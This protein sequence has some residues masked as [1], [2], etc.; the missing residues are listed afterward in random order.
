MYSNDGNSENLRSLEN[1]QELKKIRL[2]FIS[3]MISYPLW[4]VLANFLYP[5]G[6][7]PLWQRIVCSIV[8][9]LVFIST[10]LWKDMRHHFPIVY[11][12]AWMYSYHL[13]F[14]YWKNADITFYFVCN[15][16]QFPYLILCFQNKKSAQLYTY[17]KFVVVILFAFFVSYKTINPWFFVLSMITIGHYMLTV[18]VQHFNVISSLKKA[19]LEFDLALSNI[20]EGVVITN[21]LG[22]ITSYNKSAATLL[23]FIG[24]SH[25]GKSYME[26][27]LY[28]NNENL[29]G[30]TNT[31]IIFEI[32]VNT[33]KRW[34][35][36][37]SHLLGESDSSN[38]FLISFSDITLIKK[39]QELKDKQQA[40][41]AM[42]ARLSSLFAVA[43]GIA[44]EI[45]N[46]LS[47]VIGRLHTLQKALKPL[48]SD[49]VNFSITKT[50]SS[51]YRIEKVVSSLLKLSKRADQDPMEIVNL[52][53][54]FEETI[55]LFEENFKNRD[56]EFKVDEVPDIFLKCRPIQLSQV[57]FNL[58]TNAYDAIEKQDPKWIHIRLK[59]E[60]DKILIFFCD[61]GPEI[62]KEVKLRMM[63]PFF[64]TKEIGKGAGLGLSVSKA[65]IEEYGGVL[66]L[67]SN[68]VNTCFIIELKKV[69]TK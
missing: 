64:T 39:S 28:N 18:L 44:H 61:S 40:Q 25:V 65:I 9:L 58:L 14:L 3:A 21:N 68:S 5:N 54:I 48:D 57:F 6:Y 33:E 53:A 43:G 60:A 20:L 24:N 26:T 17:T 37:N 8:T 22:I 59:E 2:M 16:I 66:Y 31:N 38:N 7:D 35:Q 69:F 51:A 67:D 32:E 49:S 41:M 56:I 12:V 46:P 13:L 47:I 36:L 29:L 62:S 19:E 50:I 63:E 23:G 34:I 4:G 30:E 42:N 10:Y 52:S 15:L 1:I 27:P 45:N 55:R 11:S